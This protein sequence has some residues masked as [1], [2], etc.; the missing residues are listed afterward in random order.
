MRRCLD[1]VDVFGNCG[2]TLTGGGAERPCITWNIEETEV[3]PTIDS[4]FQGL[5]INNE[6]ILGS[7]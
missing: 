3:K 2:R 7:P 1:R 4:S 5:L 6:F